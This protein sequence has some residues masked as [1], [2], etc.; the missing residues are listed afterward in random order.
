GQVDYQP[1]A[2]QFLAKSLRSR[3]HLWEVLVDELKTGVR[4]KRYA[5]RVKQRVSDFGGS[6]IGLFGGGTLINQSDGY[7]NQLKTVRR[8]TKKLVPVFGS[9]VASPEFWRGRLDWKDNIAEWSS[10]LAE[11]PKV[12]VRG[13]LSKE[14]L[15]EAKLSNVIVCGD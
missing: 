11:L 5:K 13:P 4:V 10:A 2:S 15:V 6:S 7:L 14:I 12:G 1:N 8:N 9:G 3:S